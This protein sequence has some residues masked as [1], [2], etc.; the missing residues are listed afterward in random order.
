MRIRTLAIEWQM[1]SKVLVETLNKLGVHADDDNRE[2]TE[3]QY[4]MLCDELSKGLEI[5]ELNSID[6]IIDTIDKLGPLTA[7]MLLYER[8]VK[9]NDIYTQLEENFSKISNPEKI[10]AE[11]KV[12]SFLEFAKISFKDAQEKKLQTIVL[13]R[14]E[15]IPVK[16][17]KDDKGKHYID[18]T[19]NSYKIC[20][21]YNWR[22]EVWMSVEHITIDKNNEERLYPIFPN[23]ND[24][25]SLIH[26]KI[27]FVK[28]KYVIN[29]SIESWPQT[30]GAILSNIKKNMSVLSS[31]LDNSTLRFP[32]GTMK[33]K[34][35]V[36]KSPAIIVDVY[37]ES[38]K[39]FVQGIKKAEQ[40]LY[41]NSPGIFGS[42]GTYVSPEEKYYV[43]K[44]KVLRPRQELFHSINGYINI[45]KFIRDYYL[46]KI[47]RERM[48]ANL[49]EEIHQK[50]STIKIDVVTRDF[51]EYGAV[52]INATYL[53]KGF[54]SWN[55]FLKH[56]L[57]N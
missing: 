22:Q 20:L 55:D 11:R 56:C 34:R 26:D 1:P 29:S 31:I 28:G 54:D 49:M 8:L 17:Q 42:N 57:D 19:I 35:K 50:L 9:V 15:D 5:E 37:Q 18:V 23:A 27:K 40:P 36:W 13:D 41:D 30:I 4:N 16:H 33:V 12:L 45:E 14:H 38:E 48:S 24:L 21:E 53:P 6:A 10:N 2:L 32:D 47:K 52:S 3:Q 44:Y 51:D 46:P 25:S 43:L 7:R 39:G